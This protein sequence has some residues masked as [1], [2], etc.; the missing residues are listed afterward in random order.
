M[1]DSRELYVVFLCLHLRLCSDSNDLHGCIKQTGSVGLTILLA[2]VYMGL[3]W[4]FYKLLHVRLSVSML[5]EMLRLRE[6]R[7]NLNSLLGLNLELQ[8][9]TQLALSFL[10]LVC[11]DIF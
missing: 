3:T 7:R 10:N 6:Q 4:L 8:D 11:L 2:D 9:L 1:V 5:D